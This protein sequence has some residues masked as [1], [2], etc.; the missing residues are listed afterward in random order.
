M[1]TETYIR[2]F[3]YFSIRFIAKHASFVF[4]ERIQKLEK[5]VRL[6]TLIFR[7]NNLDFVDNLENCRQLWNLDLSFNKVSLAT[8]FSR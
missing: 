1:V 5:C 8:A 6:N 3:F 2:K 4:T 7:G